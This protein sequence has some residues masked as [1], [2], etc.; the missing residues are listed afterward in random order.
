MR[1]VLVF[2]PPANPTYMPLGMATLCEYIRAHLPQVAI[3]PVDLNL[4][5]WNRMADADT[6]SAAFRDFMRGRRGD[7]YDRDQYGQY[8]KIWS[9]LAHRFDRYERDCKVYLETDTLGDD[10]QSV[11]AGFADLVLVDTPDFVGISV[12]YPRQVVFSLALA[13]FIDARFAG[14]EGRPQMV[15]GGATI[16]A[17]RDEEILRAC[18]FV[19]AVF[20]GEGEVGLQKLCEQTP[21]DQ[22]GGLAWRNGSAIVTNRKPDT[23]PLAKIPQPRFDDLD[24][25]AYFAPRPVVPVIYSRGC[26]WRKCRF[27]AHNFSYSGYR[28]RSNAAFVE[29]LAELGQ[30]QGVRDFYF[31]DQYVDAVDMFNLYQRNYRSR[32]DNLV[33]YHGPPDGF[34]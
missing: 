24:V 2:T 1:A 7:F 9:Q 23:L 11:L 26:M 31:A 8:L 32:P 25:N 19:D 4:D 6:S 30:T 17:L 22:I 3:R 14:R 12:M 34:V 29:Y 16:S 10:F 27:C 20:S 21:Y 33:S 15:L 5:I 28:K 13:K 18:P